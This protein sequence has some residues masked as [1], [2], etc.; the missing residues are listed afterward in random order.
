MGRPARRWLAALRFVRRRRRRGR[1]TAK[2]RQLILTALSL[3]LFPSNG[4]GAT[5]G[6]RLY[7]PLNVNGALTRLGARG[8]T[9]TGDDYSPSW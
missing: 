1:D 5:V 3:L 6:Q 8:R 4:R 2:G 7:R 9:G